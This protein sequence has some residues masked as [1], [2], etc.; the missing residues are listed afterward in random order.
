MSVG[1]V[2]EAQMVVAE[3]HLAESVG[4]G[5]VKALSTP[6]LLA[7][8]E[9]AAVAAVAEHL[10]N[11]NTTVGTA[12]VLNHSAASPLG[13]RCRAT[14]RVTE[15]NGRKLVFEW[16]AWDEVELIGQGTH[17]R[18]ILNQDRFHQKLAQKTT[19]SSE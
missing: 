4:S 8:V 5:T 2:G 6:S 18:F 17:E 9:Q 11:G 12:V 1:A 15:V 7:L 10:E 14:A 13:A 19:K 3:A 16:Q